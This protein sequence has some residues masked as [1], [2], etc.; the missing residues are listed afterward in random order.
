[1]KKS[2]LLFVSV[3]IL[4]TAL[5]V[6]KHGSASQTLPAPDADYVPN[7]VL[8]KFHENAAENLK[9]QERY[10]SSPGNGHQLSQ[11]SDRKRCLGLSRSLDKVVH[12]L[13]PTGP[14]P[15]ARGA[16]NGAGHQLLKGKSARGMG[17]T[18][19]DRESNDNSQRYLFFDTL[20][21]L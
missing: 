6:S 19:W 20:G 1:M 10:R 12:F 7:E 3:L 13:S 16:G 17:R 5:V 4:L 2:V 14:S 8:V 18:E 9:P 11:A 21:P 15:G